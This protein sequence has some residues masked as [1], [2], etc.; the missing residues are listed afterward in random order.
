M[1]PDVAIGPAGDTDGGGARH[2]F[3]GAGTRPLQPLAP[4]TVPQLF[5]AQVARTPD[6]TA[7]VFEGDRLSYRDSMP[8]PTSWPSPARAWRWAGGRGRPV[9]G[10]FAEM[11]IGPL[12][13]LK[14]GG[15]YLP[16]DP[17]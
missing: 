4:A 8:G 15:A 13:I 14:A 5:A 3:G 12:G 7:V 17:D 6:A 1:Q 2:H 9:R 10:A 11:V 16:L